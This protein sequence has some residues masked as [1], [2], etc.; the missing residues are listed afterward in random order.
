MII[1][2]IFLIILILA[3]IKGFRRGLILGIFSFLAIIIG[4]AAAI[5]LSAIVAHYIGDTVNVSARWLPVISFIVVF[6]IV[7][8]LVRLGAAL[9]QKSMEVSML[10][11]VNRLGGILLYAAIYITIYSVLLFYGGK[12][13]II[14]PETIQAS[15]TYSFIA[16]WGPTIIDAF[17]YILPFFRDMFTELGTFF[18]GIGKKIS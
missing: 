8:L 16:P 1:D 9:I 18:D 10:G 17:A 6:L 4:L 14:K 7:L 3:I 2:V 15:S 5:K 11:W 12:T 13:G